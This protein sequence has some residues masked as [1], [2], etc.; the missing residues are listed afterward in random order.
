MKKKVIMAIFFFLILIP[1]WLF[2]RMHTHTYTIADFINVQREMTPEEVIELVGR[3]SSQRR[4]YNNSNVFY[5]LNDGSR[6][7]VAFLLGTSAFSIRV[8]D[9]KGRTY[10]FLAQNVFII[11]EE[12]EFRRNERE[13]TKR[14]FT[15]DAVRRH[16]REFTVAD[17]RN[18]E[19][20]MSYTEVMGLLRIRLEKRMHISNYTVEIFNIC[21]DTEMR[22]AFLERNELVSMQIIDPSG[23]VFMTSDEYHSLWILKRTR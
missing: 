16:K 17:F 18:V 23:R 4:G 12:S 8:I 10:V 6:M 7:G 1:G 11:C 3:P 14:E 15:V 20:G 19:L 21:N 5:N 13:F 22:L 2:V 9:P